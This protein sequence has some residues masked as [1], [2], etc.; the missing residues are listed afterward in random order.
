DG[1][2]VCARA[3]ASTALERRLCESGENGEEPFPRTRADPRLWLIGWN[4][5]QTLYRRPLPS[6]A[7]AFSSPEGRQIFVEALETEGLNGY[8]RLAEQSTPSPTPPSAGLV[9]WSWRSM[10]LQSILGGCGRDR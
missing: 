9:H 4:M 7:I 8:F 5:G 6:D 10:L 2:A 1:S 3:R